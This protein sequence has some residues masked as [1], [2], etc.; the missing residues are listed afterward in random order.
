MM[1]MHDENMKTGRVLVFL[2]FL[3]AAIVI[4]VTLIESSLT[5]RQEITA[6]KIVSIVLII[7]GIV[8]VFTALFTF[9]QKVTANP[10]PLETAKLRTN[11]IY[12]FIRHPMYSSVILFIIGFTLYERAYYSF[13]L[14]IFVVIFLVFKIKFEEKQLEKHFRDYQSYQA[15]TKKLIPFIY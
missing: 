1:L 9:N 4:S 12:G 14:N 2:Q 10:I 15:K 3:I 6:V 13:F 7:L 8:T 11:G 5:H